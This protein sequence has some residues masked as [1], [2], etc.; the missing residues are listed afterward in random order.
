[1]TEKAPVLTDNPCKTCGSYDSPVDACFSGTGKSNCPDRIKYINQVKQNSSDDNF[2]S[3]LIEEKDKRIQVLEASLADVKNQV[4]RVKKETAR[5]IFKEL[6]SHEAGWDGISVNAYWTKI[7]KDKYYCGD[8]E[9]RE[10]G[11][12]IKPF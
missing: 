10:L 1:M 11:V 12:N 4:E 3:K 8:I 9:T 2:Y 6:Q 5:D 7:I